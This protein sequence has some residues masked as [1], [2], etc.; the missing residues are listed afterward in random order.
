MMMEDAKIFNKDIYIMYVDFKGAFNG[1]EHR[2]MFKHMREL[3]MTISFVDA[4]EQLYGVSTTN[5]I[6]PHGITPHININIGT[7]HGDTLS[8]FSS[9]SFWNTFSCGSQSAAEATSPVPHPHTTKTTPRQRRL[10]A[11]V[12]LM[13]P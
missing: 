11:M 10:R 4:C 1:A 13:E 5:Y 2:I 7:Q 3:G 9:R 12:S 6:T 8:P